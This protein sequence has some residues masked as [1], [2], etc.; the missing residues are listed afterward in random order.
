MEI[1]QIRDLIQAIDGEFIIGDPNLLI[2]G[3]SID[4]RTIRKGEAYF[5]IKVSI[6]TDMI[7]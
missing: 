3:I 4:S 6:M 2:E 5:V 7:L 1:F